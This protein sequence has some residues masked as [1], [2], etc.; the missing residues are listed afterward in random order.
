M[1]TVHCD[2]L[3]IGG[4][5]AGITFSRM[6]RKLRPEAK[7]V[8]LRPEEFSMVYCAIPYAIQGLFDAEKVYKKDALVTDAGIELVREKAAA[9][10]LAA[11]TVTDTAG[12]VYHYA[13]LFIA[14]GASPIL[15]AIAGADSDN[16]YT[17]KTQQDMNR[18]IERIHQNAKKAVVVGAGAIGIEQ[19][20]AYQENGMEVTLV[21]MAP[22][23]LPAMVDPDMAQPLHETLEAHGVRL[24]LRLK[25]EALE[26]TRGSV[27]VVKLSDGQTIEL[28]PATD[29]VS[30]CTGMKPDLD[31]FHDAPIEIA[32]DGLVV[33]AFMRTSVED[34]YAAGDCC[35]FVSAI[36]GEPIGGKLATNAVPMAKVAACNAAGKQQVY[37]GFLNGAATCAYDHRIGAT[38]FTEESASKRGFDPIVGYG[39]TTSMFPMMPGAT[40]VKIKIV[41][42]R[43]SGRV[44]GGQVLSQV[45]ATD[46]VDVITLAIQRQLKLHELAKLSYS[47]QP[48]QSFFPAKNALVEACENAL[49]AMAQQFA[50]P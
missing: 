18:I 44:L 14:T 11:R 42:D 29:F 39:N 13:R 48:W 7:V 21:D 4:G 6:F 25:V 9:A 26:T 31:L 15:P 23:V 43:V 36:D 12:T 41:A 49:E 33:D 19:A 20:Q 37:D 34:V 17:V 30:F 46:K 32:R 27:S 5:P 8:M 24:A 40:D 47:A 3:V 28:D 2:A 35:Q 22:R 10:D 38:G 16:V 45:P 1:S 50:A